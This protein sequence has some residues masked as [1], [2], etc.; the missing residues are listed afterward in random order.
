MRRQLVALVVLLALS[1]LVAL[2]WASVLAGQGPIPPAFRIVADT[3]LTGGASRFDY[4]SLD[5]QA[6]RLYIAHLGA[7]QVTLFDTQSGAVVGDVLGVAGVHGVLAVPELG[8]VYA[9]ATDSNQLAV[10]DPSTLSIVA[11]V[12]TGDYP[13]GLAYAPTAD[14]VYV[15]NEHG[16]SDTVIDV[17]TNQSVGT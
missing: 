4:Q 8:R 14:K 7:S 15:S 6:H 1:A 10:I 16:R 13:D 5:L 11:T 3:P 9:T 17:H 12:P 2:R